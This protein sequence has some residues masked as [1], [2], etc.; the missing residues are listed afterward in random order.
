[1]RNKLIEHISGMIFVTVLLLVLMSVLHTANI[2]KENHDGLRVKEFLDVPVLNTDDRF[3]RALLKDVMNVFYPD[4][5]EKRH[6]RTRSP[7]DKK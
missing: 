7:L 4:Q 2:H 6:Y 5:Y 3:Q 1:M